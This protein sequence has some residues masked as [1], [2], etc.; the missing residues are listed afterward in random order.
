MSYRST[1]IWYAFAGHSVG[2]AFVQLDGAVN[3]YHVGFTMGSPPVERRLLKYS[4][5]DGGIDQ[6]YSLLPRKAVWELFI[7]ADTEAAYDARRD[8]IYRMFKPYEGPL[9]IRVDLAG[10]GELR[11]LSAY[12]DGPVD[13]QQSQ[14]FAYSSIVRVPL[15]CPEPL[16][17]NP[18][19]TTVQD[20][21]SVSS[22][23]F[24]YNGD[25]DEWPIVEID[26]QVQ[27]PTLSITT[28]TAYR[29]ETA[30]IDLTGVTIPNAVTWTLDM[31]KKI[32]TG[33]GGANETGKLVNPNWINFKLWPAPYKAAGLNVFN[34]TWTSKNGNAKIRLK[35]NNRYLSY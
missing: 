34:Q 17:Y 5:A 9:T 6:G 26:G 24:Y 7:K 16:W 13:F 3:A 15:Y 18:T 11:Q 25:Y 23:A 10:A 22:F 29:Y 21:F 8:A 31:R 32:L 30:I 12:V 14:Q 27:D 20:T 2:G 35:F 19:L 4:T 1:A 28:S 33:A